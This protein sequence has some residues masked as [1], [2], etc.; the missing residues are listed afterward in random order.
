MR[1]ALLGLVIF[2][3]FFARQIRAEESYAEPELL[4]ASFENRSLLSDFLSGFKR[5]SSAE[6]ASDGKFSLKWK[7]S[8]LNI[9]K[10]TDWSRYDELSIDFHNPSRNFAELV[11]EV[12][13]SFSKGYWSRVNHYFAVPPGDATIR[14]PTRLYVGEK[15]RPGRPLRLDK[16]QSVRLARTAK[17]SETTLF[18]DNIRLRRHSRPPPPEINAFDFGSAHSPLFNGMKPFTKDMHYTKDRGYGLKDAQV[19]D[20][21]PQ[22]SDALQPDSLYR[23]CIMLS[24][25]EVAVDLPPGKYSVFLNMDHPGGFWGEFPFYRQRRVFAE[26]QLAVDD[27]LSREEA[28]DRYFSFFALDDFF[29]ENVFEKYVS[30]IFRE[31]SFNIDVRDGQLNLFFAGED[32]RR[33]QCFG[34][35]L[36][37]LIIA[38]AEKE[39]ELAD[40]LR[41]VK[42]ARQKEFDAS[43]RPVAVAQENGAASGFN[44]KIV[45]FTPH[46]MKELGP[47]EA[48]GSA[49]RGAQVNIAAARG[50]LEPISFVV[51]SAEDLAGVRLEASN[52][53]GPAVIPKENIR[54]GIISPRIARVRMDGSLYTVAERYVRPVDEFDLHKQA[55]SRIW[56]TLK[57]PPDAAAG[58]YR[59][60][61]ILHLPPAQIQELAV[62][63]TV[64]PFELES[65]DFPIG[66]FNS[67]IQ[68][69]WWFEN[70]NRERAARLQALSLE[71]MRE[72]GLT[73]FSFSPNITAAMN[74]GTLDLETGEVDALMAQARRQGFLSAAAYG[75]IV[76]GIDLCRDHPPTA[77]GMDRKAFFQQLDSALRRQAARRNWLPLK[78]ILCDEPV[79]DEVKAAE[80]VFSVLPESAGDAIQYSAAFSAGKSAEY[81]TLLKTVPFP[82]LNLFNGAALSFMQRTGKQ[83]GFYN[84]ASR[85]TFGFYLYRL[86]AQTPLNYRLAWNWNQNAGNPYFALDSREDDYNWC[87]STPQGDLLCTVFLDRHVRE[88]LDDYRYA[89]TLARR[90]AQIREP[91]V[92]Q[93]GRE[94]L[95]KVL[96]FPPGEEPIPGSGYDG[97]PGAAAL[98]TEIAEF[99]ASISPQLPD[100]QPQAG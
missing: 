62:Q 98:R 64:Y 58:I 97:W 79:G 53:V 84:R 73:A 86:R 5:R 16:I 43:F 75:R 31:K 17:D 8:A 23:D 37:T 32:C 26:D 40:Y 19:W 6:H 21:Y 69:N 93:K 90:L 45:L 70:E 33:Q 59:G 100:D 89:L 47:T 68:E 91:I 27:D 41:S 99:L 35:A 52:L 39:Q 82:L 74:D 88:G 76:K 25:G 50:E 10:E 9:Q 28:R 1:L 30:R 20:P 49:L 11:L 95:Q 63:A 54:I 38:P 65:A 67:T 48:L 60:K 87:N 78:L 85:S 42:N 44:E 22:A 61:F 94:L 57:V 51:H 92:L 83:W 46:Y 80:D 34:L 77:F 36:S 29:G 71:K 24:R 14:I 7:K 66:P 55:N 13:D 15:S 12:R 72:A 3:L 56:A 96:G 18:L 4:I 81:D 2:Q